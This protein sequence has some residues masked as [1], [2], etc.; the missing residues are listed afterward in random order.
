MK[1]LHTLLLLCLAFGTGYSH[2]AAPQP[3]GGA[4]TGERYRV[5]VSTDIGGSDPDDFQSM[6][7]YLIYAD[8]FDTEGLIASPPHGGRKEHILEA[9]SAYET[10]Y[11]KLEAQSARFPSPRALRAVTTQ[12]AINPAP[13]AGYS[14]ATEGSRWIIQRARANDPRPLWILVWGSITDVAQALH[15]DPGIKPKLRV[16]F[17][18]SWNRRMDPAARDYV[19]QQHPDLWLIEADTTFR[20]MYVG[21][22]QEGDLGNREFLSRYV[23][24]HG[25]LGDLL[26]S[27]KADIKMGDTPSV[28]YLMRGN[29][30]NPASESWGGAFARPD[31]DRKYWTDNPDPALREG[32]FPGARTVNR[33]RE[34]YLRDWQQ[35]MAWL[36]TIPLSNADFEQPKLEGWTWWSR[37][38]AGSA[39]LSSDGRSG[40]GAARIRHDGEQDWAFS[41]STRVKVQPG[42]VFTASAWTKGQGGVEL[43][44]VAL[45]EGKVLT[46]SIGSD[47]VRASSQWERLSAA[48]EVPEGCDQ[49]YLRFVGR[50]ACDLLLDD[51]ALRPGGPASIKKPP[52]RG[53]AQ[54]RV[55]E[56]LDRGVVAMPMAGG[57]IYIGWR[58]LESDL[59]DTTFHLY[60]REGDAPPV[61]LSLEPL[62]QTTDF[63]DVKPPSGRLHYFLRPVNGGQEGPPSQSVSATTS[64]TGQSYIRIPLDGGHTFQKV[65]I[66]DLTGDGRYDFVIKQPNANVDPYVKYWKRSPGTYQ[67]EAY[68]H[69]GAL[70]W[71][72]DLG[73]SIE[74]GVWYSPLVVFDFDGDG[75]AEIAVKTGEGDPRDPDGRVTSG[76]EWLSIL[77][78][79]TGEEITR[80]PW[81]SRDGFPDYNYY[82]RNQLGVAYL[83]GKT[84]CL[85][86]NRG[87]YNTIKI[88]AYEFHNRQLRELWSWNDREDGP[89]YRGQGA[90]ILRAADVDGDGRDE[91]IFG[92]AVLDDN[93]AGL[94]SLG[95]GHPDHL[96]VGM[97]DPARPGLQIQYGF[98]T[99]QQKNGICMV[100][101][102]TGQILWGLDGST[103][104]IHGSGLC[105]DIDPAH[106]GVES[107]GGERDFPDKRWLFIAQGT[108]LATNDLGGLAP[109]AVY[110]DGDLQR[111]L[112]VRG[113][114]RDYGG[115]EHSTQIEGTVVAIADILGDWREEIITSVPGELR[116]YTTT[117]PATDRRVCLMQDRIYRLDV[118]GAAQGYFQIPGLTWL[119]SAEAGQTR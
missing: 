27:K 115:E 76:A 56:K 30:E 17:I 46:W 32:A 83:D 47:A 37:T 19:V 6:V 55:R 104:H 15:D 62:A 8:L 110:W 41:N 66:A 51:V 23:K 33:W 100:D 2:G 1:T 111:E 65:G 89:R 68:Q 109:R 44:V 60:R 86:V 22:R 12:G 4:L 14:T 63:V 117:I 71:R 36:R 81:P 72:R 108:L 116:I 45:A 94:W 7:H 106:P 88:V 3:S 9:I 84:P 112:L 31:A 35:R 85:I 114:L 53:H 102:K 49:I 20:G 29:P 98:E 92:A 93:G 80:T 90:H 18:S 69:D 77:D 87:T 97:L 113:R 79:L 58:L 24:G 105:A 40:R 38:G 103:A 42:Q 91:V 52:V 48:A 10:D 21:G 96:T 13:A 43:A 57:D 64:A 61:R 39:E 78:G 118:A 5:I 67:I 99:R 59:P 119:P 73:W 82:C 54:E 74:Q 107:Y 11:P 25:A 95:M 28:L 34:D 16:Y 50:G 26:V 70:L 75:R 101:A